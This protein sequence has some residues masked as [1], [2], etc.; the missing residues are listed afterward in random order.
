MNRLEVFKDNYEESIRTIE[1]FRTE[2]STMKDL[3]NWMLTTDANPFAYLPE[4]WDMERVKLLRKIK[5][6]FGAA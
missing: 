6:H 5:Q 1:R 4:G 2:P 3:V